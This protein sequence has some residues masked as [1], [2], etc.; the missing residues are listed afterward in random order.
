MKLKRYLLHKKH[1]SEIIKEN[2]LKTIYDVFRCKALW[3]IKNGVTFCKKCH[4]KEKIILCK[5][6][7]NNTINYRK[8]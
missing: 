4:Q 7:K 2:N 6:Q 3:D 1:L 8:I 5:S